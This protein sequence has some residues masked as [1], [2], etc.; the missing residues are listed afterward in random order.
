MLNLVGLES[1]IA[2]VGRKHDLEAERVRSAQDQ[3]D[4]RQPMAARRA[5]LR[6]FDSVPSQ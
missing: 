5:S 3:A 1:C 4:R 6:I 2:I